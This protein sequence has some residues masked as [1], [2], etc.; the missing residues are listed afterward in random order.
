MVGIGLLKFAFEKDCS[1]PT[2]ASCGGQDGKAGKQV[3]AVLG[4]RELPASQMQ[5]ADDI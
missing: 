1:T 5:F 2:C 4:M 3:G